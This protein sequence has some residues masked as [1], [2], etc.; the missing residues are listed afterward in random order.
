MAALHGLRCDECDWDVCS[1]C[2]SRSFLPSALVSPDPAASLS[3]RMLL[4]RHVPHAQHDDDAL[5]DALHVFRDLQV[6]PRLFSIVL[7]CA[8]ACLL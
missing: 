4:Q 1:G 7:G 6:Q 5:D 2:A 3:L 8:I